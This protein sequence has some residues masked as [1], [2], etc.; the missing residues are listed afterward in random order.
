MSGNSGRMGITIGAGMQMR[1]GLASAERRVSFVGTRHQPTA[2]LGAVPARPT[3]HRKGHWHRDMAWM[4]ILVC[5]ARAWDGQL[6]VLRWA[7]A[8]AHALMPLT[9]SRPHDFTTSRP[10]ASPRPPHPP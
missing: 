3:R 1:R 2:A 5:I 9:T 8:P 7:G 6:L 10:N 4:R